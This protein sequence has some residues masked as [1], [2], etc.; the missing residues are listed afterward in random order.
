MIQDNGVIAPDK[1]KLRKLIRKQVALI[2]K[3]KTAAGPRVFP[4]AS[5]PTSEEELPVIL[6]FPRSEPASKYSEAPR[7]LERTLDLTIEIVAKGPE[8]DEEGNEPVGK[9][10]L[11]DILDDLAEQVECEMSRDDTLNGTADDSILVNTEFEFEGAGGVPIGSARLSFAITY[12]THYPRSS[13]KQGVVDAFEKS[14]IEYNIGDNEDTREAK[15]SLDIPQ[16]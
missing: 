1:G 3:N 12:F 4:N 7:E 5:V 9:T 11:E 15:D 14:E 8:I 10:S 13:I 2:L 16:T 6:I